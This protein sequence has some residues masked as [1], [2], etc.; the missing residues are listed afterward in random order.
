LH[1]L[2]VLAAAHAGDESQLVYDIAVSDPVDGRNSAALRRN[3]AT[4]LCWTLDGFTIVEPPEAAGI[5][6][7][8]L[9]P[10]LATL[11]EAGQEAARVL[12]WGTM[13]A[14]GRS[15]PLED[16]SDATKMPPN[17]FTFQPEV[18]VLAKRAG[19]IRD[20]SLG[21]ARPLG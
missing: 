17:C 14:H 21:G 15:I 18:A 4:V 5:H 16:Q 6:L 19:V 7:M 8:K 20:F 2:A 10:L 3:G 9:G 1:D 11:D 13:I 12:R